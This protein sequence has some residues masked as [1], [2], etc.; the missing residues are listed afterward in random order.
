M[1]KMSFIHEIYTYIK[2]ATVGTL[3]ATSIIYSKSKYDGVKGIRNITYMKSLIHIPMQV[4]DLSKLKYALR[5][6]I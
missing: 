3:R 1:L 2:Y 6:K 4:H 5:T